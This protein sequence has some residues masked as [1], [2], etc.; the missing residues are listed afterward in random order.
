MPTSVKAPLPP[1]PPGTAG[2][3]LDVILEDIDMVRRWLRVNQ[4]MDPHYLMETP[5]VFGNSM[6]H[7]PS[8]WGASYYFWTS[9][10]EVVLRLVYNQRHKQHEVQSV[11]FVGKITPQDALDL[12]V[13]RTVDYL[14]ERQARSVRAVVPK[15]MRNPGI[16]KLYDLARNHFR[17]RVAV[18][19]D[20]PHFSR[21]LIDFPELTTP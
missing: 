13:D 20:S 9:E 16:L 6:G 12:A 15:Q 2:Q 11:G 18:Q 21:W 7:R 3:W 10:F 8:P 1:L 5:L 17:L 4:Q 19:A 14:R